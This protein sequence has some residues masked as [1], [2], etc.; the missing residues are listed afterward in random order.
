MIPQTK[1]RRDLRARRR[2]LSAAEQHRHGEALARRLGRDP[3][4]LRA[5][6]IGCY[7]S[8]DGELDPGPLVRLARACGKRVYLPVLRAHPYRKL[9]FVEF[10][11]GYPLTRNVFGIPEPAM[12]NRRIRLPWALDLL[13]VPLVG[14]DAAGNR[15]GMGGGFYDRTLAYRRARRHWLRPRLIGLAHECQRVERLEPRPWDVPLDAIATEAGI[16]RGGAKD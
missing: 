9:W 14:F 5:G 2:A 4:F 7:W 8:N 10:R 13:L 16:W 15:I 12:R 1:L 11:E 6:R 3:L